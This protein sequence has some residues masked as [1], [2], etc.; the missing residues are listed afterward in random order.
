MPGNIYFHSL[1]RT[2][3]PPGIYYRGRL[4]SARHAVGEKLLQ[5]DERDK[6]VGVMM[7]H[8]YFQV[9]P[10]DDRNDVAHLLGKGGPD[11]V[12]V[13]ANNTLVGVLGSER[14]PARSRMK[15]PKTHSA[16]REPAAGQAL[17][18]DQPVGAVA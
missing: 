5:C 16:G 11:V 4:S 6:A 2:K 9:S 18:G 7:D 13:V 14:S 1:K 3:F 10:D 17:S 8:S 12:P 15:T